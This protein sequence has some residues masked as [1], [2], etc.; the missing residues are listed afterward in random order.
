MNNTAGRR[1]AEAPGMNSDPLEVSDLDD[2]QR[3]VAARLARL[4][5]R[6]GRPRRNARGVYL[7]GPPGRGKTMLVDRLV[8]SAD[9]KRV[10]RRHFHEFFAELH[11]AVRATGAIEQAVRHSTREARLLCFDEFHAE[12]IGDAMI[13]ARVLDLLFA[14]GVVLV[15]TSNCAPAELLPNPLFHDRFVPTI[16]ALT[17]R[18]DVLALDGPV[19][20]RTRAGGRRTGFAAGRY[21]VGP[22]RAVEEPGRVA[23][24]HSEVRALRVDAEEVV[25]AFADLC[26]APV[27]AADYLALTRR[28][29]R[30]TLTEVPPLAAAPP[31]RVTRLLNLVDVLY[32]TDR[33]LSVYARAPLAELVREVSGIPGFARTVSRLSEI[34]QSDRGS[35]W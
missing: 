24:G 27:S 16:D 19:D 10:L 34:A 13:V 20:Y 33:E 4:L 11:A 12:D 17:A 5:D 1:H 25:F 15:T 32:D 3:A 7:Y 2:R 29:R 30:W 26:G 31:D 14:R 6:R 28:F 8:A 35:D 22:C 23:V 18:M 9:P 21:L